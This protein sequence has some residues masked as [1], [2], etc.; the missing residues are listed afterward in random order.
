MFAYSLY[1]FYGATM[2]LKDRLQ[3]ACLFYGF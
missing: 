1:Y 3:R 2:T